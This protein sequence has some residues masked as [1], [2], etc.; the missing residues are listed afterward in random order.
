MKRSTI[1]SFGLA[2]LSVGCTLSTIP[3]TPPATRTIAPPVPATI[4]P[5][6][7]GFPPL[8]GSALAFDGSDDYV[9]VQDHPSLDLTSSFTIAA[10]IYLEEYTEWASLVT[11][12]DKPNLNNYAVHQSG[13]FDPLYRTEFGHLRFSGCV[14]LSAPL[15]ESQTVL[16]LRSWQ[17]VAVT[18]DGTSLR[19]YANGHPDGTVNVAGPLCTN[20]SP[21]YIGVDHPLTTEYW[22]GAIDELGIWSFALSETQIQDLMNGAQPAIDA[23]LVGYWSF[24]EGQGA[25]ANDRSM[26]ANHGQLAGDPSWSRPLAPVP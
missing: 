9:I 25:I 26:Y 16:P 22:H 14:G 3:R 7:T 1:L 20:D 12:G 11:K 17:F 10:W 18:F 21:L 8:H 24:D 4:T 15:P 23:T 19:F 13:P 6:P 5:Q 2:L